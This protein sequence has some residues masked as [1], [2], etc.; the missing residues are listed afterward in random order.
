MGEVGGGGDKGGSWRDVDDLRRG[1]GKYA[2]HIV[3]GDRPRAD[4]GR[5]G[6]GCMKVID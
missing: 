6:S 4:R 3:L 1:A 5:E 2:P